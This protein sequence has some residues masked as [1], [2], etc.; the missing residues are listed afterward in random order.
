MAGEDKCSQWAVIFAMILRKITACNC[1]H[2]CCACVK[3]VRV[4]RHLRAMWKMFRHI[5]II[6]LHYVNMLS[7][8]ILYNYSFLMQCAL[9][10]QSNTQ[11]AQF[12][13]K[14][15]PFNLVHYT[16]THKVMVR[17]E[18]R[19]P[20]SRHWPT[21]SKSNSI[22]LHL[23]ILKALHWETCHANVCDR[24]LH[25]RRRTKQQTEQCL[26]ETKLVKMTFYH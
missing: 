3:S 24:S 19:E 18:V 11:S 8:L 17:L 20:Y 5:S 12:K 21:Q 25:R 22:L 26:P 2:V 13:K 6:Y 10:G 23:A 7:W 1:R 16:H 9:V 14:R 4:F 15:H